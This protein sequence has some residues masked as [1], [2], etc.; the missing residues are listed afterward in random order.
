MLLAACPSFAA[1][2]VV[3]FNATGATAK[4]T[5][6]ADTSW[7][8]WRWDG[9]LMQHSV[10]QIRD[11]DGDGE[12]AATFGSA[13]STTY[14]AGCAVVDIGSGEFDVA[15][16]DGGPGEYSPLPDGA[17]V[18]GTSGEATEFFLP[19]NGTYWQTMWVRPGG[20]VWA[21]TGPDRDGIYWNDFHHY[22]TSD[23]KGSAVP[24]GFAAGDLLFA[25]HGSHGF[26]I[27]EVDRFLAST[28][29]GVV[30]FAGNY[31]VTLTE[32][33]AST[34]TV[35]LYRLGGT[36]G[37]IS[38]RARVVHPAVAPYDT[39]LTFGPGEVRKNIGP[40]ASVN[41]NVFVG[42]WRKAAIELYA[43]V[44][45]SIDDSF[46]GSITIH[47]DDVR[48]VLTLGSGI[49]E[50]IDEPDAPLPL[51]IPIRLSAPA[52][53]PVEVEYR[54]QRNPA[55][56]GWTDV[57]GTVTLTPGQTEATA[58]VTI[59]TNASVEENYRYMV[60]LG[61]GAE[62]IARLGSPNSVTILVIDDE[63]PQIAIDD[64]TFTE[65]AGSV[66]VPL[67]VI[68]STR[69]TTKYTWTTVDGTALAGS[70]YQAASG[71]TD[72]A[73]RITLLNDTQVE[74]TETFYV[75]LRDLVDVIAPRQRVA[76][77]IADDESKPVLSI[78]P[79]TIDEGAAGQRTTANVT[80]ELSAPHAL[81]VEVAYAVN[82]ATAT[83]GIDFQAVPPFTSTIIPAGST[84]GSA[85][86]VILGDDVEEPD[87]LIVV[88]ISAAANATVGQ[89]KSAIITIIDDDTKVLPYLSIFDATVT[90]GTGGSS[91]ASFRVD[92]STP[93]TAEL[94]VDYTTSD[95]SATAGHDYELARGTVVFAPGE[96]RKFIDVV[97]Y[98]DAITEGT[99]LFHVTL[100]PTAAVT[101]A[102]QVAQGRITDDDA[103]P[104]PSVTIA[105]VTVKEGDDGWKPIALTLTLSEPFA[106][107]VQI[108]TRTFAVSATP[109]VDFETNLTTI[110]IPAGQTS[111]TV[112]VR[113]AG[114]W[115]RE[116]D[117]TFE[118]RIT[119]ANGLSIGD[120][121]AVVTIVDDD[122]PAGRRRSVR[123]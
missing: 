4:V 96:R 67:R 64:Q 3:T 86:V 36:N 25:V 57:V 102:R 75:E 70:D 45:T 55:I 91:I 58:T 113:V 65:S 46:T 115:T 101:L 107:P 71:V 94:R 59:P 80:F 110:T 82:A 87:E 33:V 17:I 56:N 52:G 2:S 99:E 103:P 43:P 119:G 22:R 105:D 66:L 109:D 42:D 61:I 54:L 32:N 106:Q 7:L 26:L 111:A 24:A 40:F 112:I 53:V 51:T 18:R 41:D 29:A 93:M 14:R 74:G 31:G 8:C 123:H 68:P 48:P 72:Q 34:A 62:S 37:T 9:K 88:V 6:G 5:A 39:L 49:P 60:S 81:P 11:S 69:P 116:S 21:G 121:R 98:S 30:R 19:S 12:V 38:V 100:L 20:G 50:Q 27:D 16:M 73:V 120:D 13:H 47:D 10:V 63:L 89:P 77:T 79:V 23:M 1:V 97:V 44:G 122:A 95:S 35:P 76:I 28:A 85:Q 117:E 15:N 84:I 83:A 114:D 90:E 108:D 118:V 78:L 92:L 104:L